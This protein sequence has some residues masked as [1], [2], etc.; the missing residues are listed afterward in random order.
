M[1]CFGVEYQAMEES[2]KNEISYRLELWDE[3][4]QKNT[5]VLPHVLKDLRIYV[6]QRGIWVDKSRTR[7][8]NSLDLTHF[9]LFQ[10]SLFYLILL[11]T[12]LPKRRRLV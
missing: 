2:V 9:S 3:L 8:I 5:R 1:G 12:L 7:K 6:P 10:S 11:I 4:K